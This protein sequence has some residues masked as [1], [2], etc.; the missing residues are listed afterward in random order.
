M[1][2]M[3]VRT[4]YACLPSTGTRSPITES[5]SMRR[6]PSMCG[7]SSRLFDGRKLSSFW[8]MATAW[9]SSS[10]MKCVTPEWVM[11][12]SGPPSSSAVTC[13]PVTCR[14]TCGP[15]MNICDWRVWMMKSVSAGLYAA[16]PAHGPQMSEICGTA[17]ESI[18][19]EWKTLP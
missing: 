11:C 19:F 18:T 17:P 13:S 14:M 7:G 12:A 15:V 10:A 6:S 3:T 5:A 2:S 4:S 1:W 8:Q 16:P 9:R